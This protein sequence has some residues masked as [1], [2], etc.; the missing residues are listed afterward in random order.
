MVAL[1]KRGKL[2]I[3]KDT[4]TKNGNMKKVNKKQPIAVVQGSDN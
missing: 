4:I 3:V 2:V 1:N